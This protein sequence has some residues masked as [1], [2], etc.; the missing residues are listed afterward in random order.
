M[1]INR[2]VLGVVALVAIMSTLQ[3]VQS[4]PSHLQGWPSSGTDFCNSEYRSSSYFR[5]HLR[6]PHMPEILLGSRLVRW[7]LAI[8]M[9]TGTKSTR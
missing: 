9:D 6:R 8:F 7:F 1:K 2:L 3:A 5:Q 4:W